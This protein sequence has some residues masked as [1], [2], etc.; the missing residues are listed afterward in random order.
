MRDDQT[1]RP[2]PSPDAPMPKPLSHRTLALLL[3]VYTASMGGLI[4]IL[5]LMIAGYGDTGASDAL[6]LSAPFVLLLCA[7]GLA[8]YLIAARLLRQ[9]REKRA[10]ACVCAYAMLPWPLMA[11]LLY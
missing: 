5:S 7:L 4:L 3:G 1:S 11:A 2:S 6:S 9:G 8:T 10:M